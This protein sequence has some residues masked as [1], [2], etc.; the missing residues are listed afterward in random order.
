MTN[1]LQGKQCENFRFPEVELLRKIKGNKAK[2]EN[3]QKN[4]LKEIARVCALP[5]SAITEN[6]N[7]K[8]AIQI[9]EFEA[10]KETCG[11][12]EK[13]AAKLG[14]RI[15]ITGE[16]F[17]YKTRINASD[18]SPWAQEVSLP[19]EH[20]QKH[21]YPEGPESGISEMQEAV[22]RQ[23]GSL[24]DLLLRTQ[25]NYIMEMEDGLPELKGGISGAAIDMTKQQKVT[26][27][28][29]NKR[30]LLTMCAAMQKGKK[31][32]TRPAM[33]GNETFCKEHQAAFKSQKDEGG[34]YNLQ[35]FFPVG[36]H[37]IKMTAVSKVFETVKM[38][39]KTRITEEYEAR[40]N[41]R[42]Q[43]QAENGL[44]IRLWKW[45]ETKWDLVRQ[46]EWSE[47]FVD[48]VDEA[49]GGTSYE[50]DGWKTVIHQINAR[51]QIRY[52]GEYRADKIAPIS[53]LENYIGM[54]SNIS[55]K[56]GGSPLT[57]Q[58]YHWHKEAKLSP[59]WPDDLNSWNGNSHLVKRIVPT[60]DGS[61]AP[62]LA[63][64]GRHIMTFRARPTGKSRYRYSIMM[65]YDVW[66]SSPTEKIIRKNV[67]SPLQEGLINR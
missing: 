50:Q 64:G 35:Y 4:A 17:I 9:R 61:G 21:L 58:T 29:R 22:E 32:C 10:N 55:E 42:A 54:L 30:G 14:V 60:K 39:A 44:L 7:T 38:A 56:Q 59:M 18:G 24:H 34:K 51:L 43:F 13:A 16:R 11:I 6:D 12:A 67:V 41:F 23:G 3:Q 62:Q 52:Y 2:V 15:E 45:L 63:A 66:T 37:K 57:T 20:L 47:E 26:T 46:M 28:L 5:N 53:M 49:V 19:V 8:L 48:E 40:F 25:K 31:F 33:R 65:I 1:A 27:T 36:E